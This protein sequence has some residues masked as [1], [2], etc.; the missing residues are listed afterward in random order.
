[1]SQFQILDEGPRGGGYGETLAPLFDAPGQADQR[2]WGNSQ[3]SQSVAPQPYSASPLPPPL[4]PPAQYAPYQAPYP[5]YPTTSQPRYSPG[6]GAPAM[7]MFDTLLPD[8]IPSMPAGA[9]P[10]PPRRGLLNTSTA[11]SPVVMND[12]GEQPCEYCAAGRQH[13]HHHHGHGSSA[14]CRGAYDHVRSCPTCSKHLKRDTRFFLVIIALL[15]LIAG[16]LFFRLRAAQRK[17]PRYASTSLG[18][19]FGRKRQPYLEATKLGRML[20]QGD[21]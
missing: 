18:R 1:M 15:L 2:S 21:E 19:S 6:M 11:Q 5:P 3:Y 12:P 8:G 20:Q 7:P 13:Y 4:P 9:A 17:L 14:G 10:P 16:I